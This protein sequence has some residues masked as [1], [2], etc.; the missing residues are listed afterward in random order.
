MKVV[1]I[2]GGGAALVALRVMKAKNPDVEPVLLTERDVGGYRPCEL[3]YVLSGEIATYEEIAVL[4]DSERA[5]FRFGRSATAIDLDAR[6]VAASG[7]DGATE[8]YP[9]DKLLIASGARPAMPPV[10]GLDDSA[11][12]EKTAALSTDMSSFKRLCTLAAD[13]KTAVV[14]GAGAIGLEVAEGL[15]AQGLD[16][17]VFEVAPRPLLRAFDEVPAQAIV[18]T[19]EGLGVDLRLDTAIEGIEAD[20]EGEG[21]GVRV[22]AGGETLRADLIAVCAGFKPNVEIARDAGIALGNTGFI[23]CDQYRRTSVDGVYASGDCAESFNLVTNRAE[24]NMLAINAVVTGKI[25][26]HNIALGDNRAVGGFVPSIIVR[27]GGH[28]FGAVGLTEEQALALGYDAAAATHTAPGKPK[29]LGGVPV[30][31]KLVAE[32]GTGRMLGAQMW[33]AESV[34]GELDRLALAI[35]HR[36]AV[37]ALSVSISC[38]TPAV[39]MPYTP[40][41][42]ALDKLLPLL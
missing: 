42:Q 36:L 3:T 4:G 39:T 29:N 30:N 27:L 24:P 13:A 19:M 1:C 7:P 2:G 14:M 22:L 5:D 6:T 12:A 32:R 16:V 23:A 25:A 41:A 40:V 18:E 8:T 33:S 17:T 35:E 31:A 21:A 9:F 37:D 20:G 38:Y 34:A 11:V 10:E 26:G 28:F 15:R